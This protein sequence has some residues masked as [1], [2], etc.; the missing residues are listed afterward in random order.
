MM[1][2]EELLKII[3]CPKCQGE[4]VYDVQNKNLSCNSCGKIFQVQ[5]N[6]PK[7]IIEE[8]KSDE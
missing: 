6:I 4:L 8:D 7:L 5:N 2:T 3:C 1:L